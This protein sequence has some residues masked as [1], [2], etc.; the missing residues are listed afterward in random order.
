MYAIW[1]INSSMSMVSFFNAIID[2][3]GQHPPWQRFTTNVINLWIKQTRSPWVSEVLWRDTLIHKEL[4]FKRNITNVKKM[5]RKNSSLPQKCI[6][7]YYCHMEEILSYGWIM[8]Q[9]LKAISYKGLRSNT[10]HLAKLKM[11]W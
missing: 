9:W 1:L 7:N 3:V 8:E 6:L 11:T 4:A 2:S 10:F 5:R